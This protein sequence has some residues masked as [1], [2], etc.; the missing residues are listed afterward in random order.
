MTRTMFFASARWLVAWTMASLL[1]A[2]A[3]AAPQINNVAPRGLQVGGATIVV[4][5]GAELLPD[6]RLLLPVPIASQTIREGATDNRLEIAVVLDASVPPGIYPLRVANARGISNVALIGV[7]ALPQVAFA[8]QA[9]S[10]PAAM[11]GAL[12]GSGILSTRFTGTAGQRVVVDVEAKRLGGGLNPVVHLLSADRLQ[13]AYASAVSS[14]GGDARVVATLPADG[15]YI[16]ELHDA[17]YRGEG[18]G[19]FRL[20]IG[21]LHFADLAFPFAV[22]RGSTAVLQVSDGSLPGANVDFNSASPLVAAPSPW[23]AANLLTGSRP[24][25][26]LS[27]AAEAVEAPPADGSLQQI[28]APGGFH[29]RLADPHEEDRFRLTVEP[30]TPLRFEVFAGRAGTPLD[31]VLT[32]YNE[33]GAAL[34][35]ADDS[36]GT[37]DPVLDFG[38]PGDAT[39][40][41]V[42]IRDLLGRGGDAFVYRVAI[43]RTDRP[44]FSL[45]VFEDRQH[46]PRGGH[47]VIRV[48]ANRAGYN[49]PIKLSLPELMPGLTLV[50]DEIPA[51][52]TDALLSLGGH[53]LSPAQTVTTLLGT[54]T[55]PN[56]PLTRQALLPET[57]ATRLQP[58]LR[59]ELGVAVTG[60]APLGVAWAAPSAEMTLPIGGTLPAS[61]AIVRAEGVQG[62]VRLS[63]VTSQI[64]PQKN[65]NNVVTDDLA[66]ALRVDGMPTIP[67]D[68]SALDLAILVPGDLPEIPYDLAIVAELLSADGS[69]VVA[70]ATTESRRFTAIKPPAP[71][72]EQP[73][74]V[75][76]DQPEFVAA[77][78]EGGGTA[79][80]FADD[81]HAGTASVRVTPDQKFNAALPGLGVKIRENPQPGEYRYLR[82]AWKKV[83]GALICLQLNHDGLWGPA[84]DNPAKF[85]YDAGSGAESY[86]AAVRVDGALPAGWTVVTRDLFADFGEFTL[87]GLALSPQ[88]GEAGLFDHIYLGRGPQDFDLV[89]PPPVQ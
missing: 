87:T 71:P 56:V 2:A 51:N 1:A 13:L 24:V 72:A 34:S 20:K 74:A 21:D 35:S 47:A 68:Q 61:I 69:Q 25:V 48:R 57:P 44:N 89:A 27:D 32:L 46:V 38:V 11:T 6:A 5:D 80:L 66:R 58:W 31:G 79:T 84:G 67:A 28:A 7:D 81:K 78:I 15:E 40:L 17:V 22:Q 41:I 70:R 73:L 39:S 59:G 49:G 16:V 12:A 65:E 82:F 42:G 36:P 43:T 62:P 18:P 83:G 50:G 88:D 77:L 52:A 8:P 76:E 9:A 19:H 55:D 33:Q 63:L 14:I 75:F 29:G 26:F 23:P 3:Q 4:V 53:E 10:L 64:V 30:N 85:R 54:S 45:T 60:P 37:T 86:G